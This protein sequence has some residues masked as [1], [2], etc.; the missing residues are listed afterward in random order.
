MGTRPPTVV[1][2][3]ATAT[4]TMVVIAHQLHEPG[5]EAVKTMTVWVMSAFHLVPGQS[6][7]MCFVWHCACV[8]SACGCCVA[9]AL[10]SISKRSA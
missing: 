5:E 6:G 9:S 7:W 1:T 8:N 2:A 3:R 10:V 4:A